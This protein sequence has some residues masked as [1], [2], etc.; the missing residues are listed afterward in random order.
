MFGDDVDLT[1]EVILDVLVIDVVVN[2]ASEVID[3]TGISSFTIDNV[4]VGNIV[5]LLLE[6]A[7]VVE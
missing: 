4:G 5:F 6:L 7:A 1:V 3:A 2:F